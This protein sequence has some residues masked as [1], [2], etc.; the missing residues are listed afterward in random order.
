MIAS[1]LSALG[2]LALLLFVLAVKGLSFV[3]LLRGVALLALLIA[4]VLL[5]RSAFLED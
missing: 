1:I 2:G 5:I 3:I 4:A